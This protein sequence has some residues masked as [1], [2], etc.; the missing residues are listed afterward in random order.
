MAITAISMGINPILLMFTTAH[1]SSL[2]FMLPVGTLT[3]AIAYGNGYIRV[4]DMIIA[5]FTLNI[6]GVLL[7]KIFMSY[8]VPVV[9][10]INP[11]LTDWAVI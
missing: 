4:K 3:N 9:M 6:I 10:G 8:I 7:V 2:G 1:A 5:G 11:G